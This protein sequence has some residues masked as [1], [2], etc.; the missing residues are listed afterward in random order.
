MVVKT[1][2]CP[3]WRFQ[4]LSLVIQLDFLESGN[5]DIVAVE[6]SQQFSD[7]SADSI[8]VPSVICRRQL[9]GVG[10]ESGPGFIS[11]SPAH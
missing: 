6:Q 3:S 4:R 9:V 1:H 10:V 2:S 11:M 7:F 8:C 5:V